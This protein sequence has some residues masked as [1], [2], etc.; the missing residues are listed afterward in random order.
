MIKS[1]R[2]LLFIVLLIGASLNAQVKHLD[3]IGAGHDNKVIITSSDESIQP[4]SKVLDGFDIQEEDQL[5]HASRFL[6]HATFGVDI[7]TI[8]I[9]AAMGYDAWL[10]EQ[11][12]LPALSHL[13]E[14]DIQNAVGGLG[15]GYG[16]NNLFTHRLFGTAWLTNVMT[17][18]DILRQRMTFNLSQIMV[19]NS[20]SDLFKKGGSSIGHYYDVLQNNAFGNYQN[21]LTD[22]TF[23]AAMADFLTYYNNPKED[24]DNNIHPDENYAREIMQLF[25]IGLWE[26][27]QDG[28]R[29]LDGDN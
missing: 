3:Y 26:L 29:K 18:P 13:D 17:S 1:I 23:N 4:S 20:N 24:L 15:Y 22:V 10:E 7:S 6:A 5:I 28:T 9:C 27:N 16:P 8:Q 11:L 25:S 2:Y 14:M 19:M 12:N 21:L